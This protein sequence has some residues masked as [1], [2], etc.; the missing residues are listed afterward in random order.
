MN[1][2]IKHVHAN[3]IA[4]SLH[5]LSVLSIKHQRVGLIALLMRNYIHNAIP[6][7]ASLDY[8]T[9]NIMKPYVKCK[10]INFDLIAVK[11]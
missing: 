9:I 6:C 10:V 4:C 8:N 11:I 3:M 2:F 7:D 5:C 1:V